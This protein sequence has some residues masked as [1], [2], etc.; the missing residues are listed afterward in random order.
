M[1]DLELRERLSTLK[2]DPMYQIILENKIPKDL[3]NKREMCAFISEKIWTI[4]EKVY[5]PLGLWLQNPDTEGKRDFGVVYKND[6]GLINYADTNYSGWEY[7]FN[8]TH[9]LFIDY[10]RNKK[11]ETLKLC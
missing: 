5:Q 6:W 4:L 7:I 11:I 3:Y 8:Q 1:N 9:K 10:C 2:R